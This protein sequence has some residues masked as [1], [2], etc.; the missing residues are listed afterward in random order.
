MY[1]D[2]ELQDMAIEERNDVLD[3]LTFEYTQAA[4]RAELEYELGRLGF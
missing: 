3:Q 1:T 4:M 2:A